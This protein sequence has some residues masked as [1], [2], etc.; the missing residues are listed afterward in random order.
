ML[1]EVLRFADDLT[2]Q[3]TGEV[4]VEN[5]G[6]RSWTPPINTFL[7]PLTED[8]IIDPAIVAGEGR[9]LSPYLMQFPHETVSTLLD[10]LHFQ[11]FS[12]A[13]RI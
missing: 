3:T 9:G 2:R 13:R 8:Y 10:V 6:S 12:Q 5:P 4:A 1:D 11:V 7:S